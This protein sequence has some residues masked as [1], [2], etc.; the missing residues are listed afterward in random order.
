MKNNYKP[1]KKISIITINYNNYKGLVDTANS[2]INQT[3][4]DIEYIIID[5][6]STD[7]SKEYIESISEHLDYWVSEPD[8]GIYNAMNKGIKKATGDYLFFLNSGDYFLDINCLEKHKKS[9]NDFEIIYF[10][11]YYGNHS[12]KRKVIYPDFL[13]FY[14]FFINTICHQAVF[15]K[16]TLFKEYGLYDESLKILADWE[17]LLKTIFIHQVSYKHIDDFIV[18]YDD[19]GFSSNV[20][21]HVELK[22]EKH[23]VLKKYFPAFIDDYWDYHNKKY[24]FKKFRIYKI[25][26]FFKKIK[27]T[28]KIK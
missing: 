20:A 27:N 26:V 19:S 11:I 8:N 16:N 4:K 24:Y 23:I 28:L 6:G 22:Q 9:F 3:Y 7:E 17:F 12:N 13:N 18:L 21:N 14:L 2:V 15:F 10:N 5:G 1:M 25:I